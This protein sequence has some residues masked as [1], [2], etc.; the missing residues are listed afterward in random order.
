MCIFCV[1]FACSLY[2]LCSLFCMR[3]SYI[4]K[5]YLIWFDLFDLK[6]TSLR[7]TTFNLGYAG[8]FAYNCLNAYCI[9]LPT[10]A[11]SSWPLPFHSIS[12]CYT[13]H[14]GTA[15]LDG[16]LTV[17]CCNF[18]KLRIFRTTPAGCRHNA[19]KSQILS[20]VFLIKNNFK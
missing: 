8:I 19:V 16:F 17:L 9:L 5:T 10:P 20:T 4:I 6:L 3:L 7:L 15:T 18:S 12:A 11:F 2:Y 13:S 1:L 14:N